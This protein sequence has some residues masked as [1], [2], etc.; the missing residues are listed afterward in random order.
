MIKDLTE[1]IKL[2]DQINS[3][4]T[5]SEISLDQAM[6]NMKEVEKNLDKI[7][8]AELIKDKITK[9]R[10]ILK[11]NDPDMS[12]VLS[13]LNEANNIFVVE[14]EWRKRAKNDLLPQLNEFDNAIKDTIGL[15]LQERLTLEQAKFV[16][17]CRSSHKDISLNF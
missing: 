4:G 17:R 16:S 9:S 6:L 7:S 5:K 14:K 15:R 10:R 8:G 11:K 12:K 13:L 3:L 2:E 1:L